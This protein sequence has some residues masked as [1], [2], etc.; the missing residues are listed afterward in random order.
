MCEIDRP[1]KPDWN[2]YF[3]RIAWIVK[4]RANCMKRSI[5]AVIVKN[6]RIV[7]TGYNGTPFGFDNCYEDGCGRCNSNIQSG[8]DLDKCICLHAEENAILEAGKDFISKKIN[9]F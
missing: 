1:F 8:K 9:L 7:S 2:D 5:G 4:L 3:M 6:F